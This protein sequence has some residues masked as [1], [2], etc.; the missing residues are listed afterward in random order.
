[1]SIWLWPNNWEGKPDLKRE[2]AYQS[3]YLLV[4]EVRSRADLSTLIL[5]KNEIL[6]LMKLKISFLSSIRDTQP[7]YSL[8]NVFISKLQAVALAVVSH[9]L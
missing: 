8:V 9:E 3:G 2:L 5:V 4:T 7:D 1:M 6:K